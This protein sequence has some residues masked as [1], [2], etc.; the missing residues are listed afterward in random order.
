MNPSNGSEN[1]A[2]LTRKTTLTQHK[3]T[4]GTFTKIR[5]DTGTSELNP[6]QHAL[7]DVP[8]NVQKSSMPTEDNEMTNHV[9]IIKEEVGCTFQG[10]SNMKVLL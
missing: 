7:T 2:F 9:H 5:S 3:E 10:R 1:V 4:D 8:E 6:A